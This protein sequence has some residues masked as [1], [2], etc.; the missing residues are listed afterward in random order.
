[1]DLESFDVTLA[2]CQYEEI[3]EEILDDARRPHG[4]NSRIIVRKALVDM[5][6]RL[7]TDQLKDLR[8]RYFNPLD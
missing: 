8:R 2:D 5:M 7:P 1:M 3:A 4:I 6:D